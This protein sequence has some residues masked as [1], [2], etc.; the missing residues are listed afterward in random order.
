VAIAKPARVRNLMREVI[1]SA[2]V[3]ASVHGA[4]SG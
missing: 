4:E 3:S 1:D 2:P